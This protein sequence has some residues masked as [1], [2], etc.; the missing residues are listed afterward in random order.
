MMFME[1]TLL[2]AVSIL[3]T[4]SAHAWLSPEEGGKIDEAMTLTP[5]IKNGKKI[6][7]RTCK[8]C[9][10]EKGWGMTTDAGNRLRPGAYPQLAGQH[11]SVLIKQLLDIRNLNR[12]N[13]TMYPFTLPQYLGGG[14]QGIADVTAYIGTLPEN[15]E[16]HTGDGSDLEHGEDIYKK[17]CARCHG[18]KGEGDA[19]NFYPRLA[20]QHYEY[21]L[22]QML[23]IQDRKRRNANRKMAKQIDRFSYKDIRAVVDYASRLTGE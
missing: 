5:D 9:H 1:R 20:N 22:R 23:W 3:A 7:D 15:S 2:F 17:N 18:D 13:P 6:Y 14:M 8:M 21:M 16:Q 12:D 4:A 19:K 10:T 11:Q